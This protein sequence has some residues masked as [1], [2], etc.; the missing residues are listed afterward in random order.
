MPKPCFALSIYLVIE[1][2]R[3]QCMHSMIWGCVSYITHMLLHPN[4]NWIGNLHKQWICHLS[5]NTWSEGYR[6]VFCCGCSSFMFGYCIFYY[7]IC[8]CL[9]Y[10]GNVLKYNCRKSSR[11][12]LYLWCVCQNLWTIQWMMQI[13]YSPQ[14]NVYEISSQESNFRV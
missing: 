10:T 6:K 8:V 2:L 11:I 14:N 5:K 13:I 9:G 12:L 3:R 4:C 7:W 1:W